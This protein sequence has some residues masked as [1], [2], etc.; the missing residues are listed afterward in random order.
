MSELFRK[1]AIEKQSQRHF[2]DVFL[3][4][5][6]SFWAIT[7]LIALIM[8]GLVV[9][10]L[11]GEYARKERVV[12]VIVPSKG[13]VQII[14][15]QTGVFA[16]IFVDTGD[17]VDIGTQLLKIKNDAAL[18]DGN[19]IY[20]ALLA[21]METEKV[22]LVSLLQAVP[23]QY[24]LTESRLES[25]KAESIGE[26][27]RARI[28]IRIQI[29]TMELEKDLLERMQK[30]FKDEVV[31]ML[32]VTTQESSYLA[33]RQ[34]LS[35]L[36]NNRLK[37]LAQ[38]RDIEARIVM[39]VLEQATQENEIKNRI[40]ALEQNIIR[41]DSQ[42]SLIIRSPVKGYVTTITVRKGQATS[43]RPVM[44]IL[45]EGGELL[46]ELFVPARAAG[47]VKAGQSVRLLYDA[48]PYQK[49]G[50]FDGQ[51]EHV[52]KTV[53]NT[54]NF[55]NAPQL[56][57]PVFLVTVTLNQQFITTMGEKFP[58][59]AGMALSADL[60]LEDRKIWEWAFGPLLGAMR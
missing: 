2:G 50:F 47:F 23:N 14:P 12:G 5:P 36:E 15:Q 56:P 10:A 59:Q 9:V 52:S 29:R 21:E 22:S 3:S 17:V 42:S 6:L 1:E 32:E 46:V 16:E 55:T 25:Q 4:T 28:Q 48:F 53:I 54:A 19:S 34:T 41:T 24:E 57:E 13:L 38:A 30:L 31:S 33:T 8:V 44:S 60:I 26:A 35:D 37:V 40:S 45:P 58:L 51:V 43:A 20:E 27:E 49:F 11:F 7:G 39:L 18:A